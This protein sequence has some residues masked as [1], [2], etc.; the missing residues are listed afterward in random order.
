MMW[1][2]WGNAPG[3]WMALGM[4]SMVVFWG[5]VIGLVVWTVNRLAGGPQRPRD[6]ETPLEIARQRLARGEITREQYEEL[7]QALR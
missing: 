5:V 2:Y 6:Q 1:G 3:W 7:R 4:L